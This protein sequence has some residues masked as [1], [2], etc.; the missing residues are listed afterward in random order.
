MTTAPGCEAATH[1]LCAY[2]ERGRRRRSVKKHEETIIAQSF[3]KC[4][5][6]AVLVHPFIS[7]QDECIVDADVQ[8]G[9]GAIAVDILTWLWVRFTYAHMACTLDIKIGVGEGG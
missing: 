7:T 5:A 8:V 4:K 3:K 2:A 1:Q 9:I 6:P